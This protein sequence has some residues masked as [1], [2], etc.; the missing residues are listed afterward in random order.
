MGDNSE[1][2]LRAQIMHSSALGAVGVRSA[3]RHYELHRGDSVAAVLRCV[4]RSDVDFQSVLLA[5]HDQEHLQYLHVALVVAEA[6]Q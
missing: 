5:D 3:G 1:G 4:P 2:G 6:E